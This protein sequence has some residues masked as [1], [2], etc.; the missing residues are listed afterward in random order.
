M[1][2]TITTL[3]LS[4]T[5][6]IGWFASLAAAPNQQPLSDV[7]AL[8]GVSEGK[9]VFD[10]GMAN[11]QTLPLYLKVIA[12][13]HADLLRQKVTPNIILAFRGGAVKLVSNNREALPMEHH[14]KLEEIAALLADLQQKPGVRM[15]V[16][17]LATNLMG[18]DNGTILPGIKVVGN[19][20]VS[21]TGYHAQGYA[22]IPIH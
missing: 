11:P 17:A 4:L 20:F 13:T 15:E 3:L 10:I 14:P 1:Q 2:K 21:L 22:A 5:L 18:V 8:Q 12:Q 7:E 6:I 16:C 9:V 19:T